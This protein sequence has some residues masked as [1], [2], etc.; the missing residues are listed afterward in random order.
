MYK[1]SSFSSYGVAHGNK[2]DFTGCLISD[3]DGKELTKQGFGIGTPIGASGTI[4]TDGTVE[5]VLSH[6]NPAG[7][8]HAYDA[9]GA[10]WFNVSLDSVRLRSGNRVE[11]LTRA[12][13]IHISKLMVQVHKGVVRLVSTER[14]HFGKSKKRNAGAR[15]YGPRVRAPETST[16]ADS[17]TA[18]GGDQPFV[19]YVRR[20][21]DNFTLLM[22][23]SIAERAGLAEGSRVEIEPV[24][25]GRLV[26]SR[27]K[28][29]FTLDELLAGMT[30]DREHPLEDDTPRGEESL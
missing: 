11:R 6:A 21:G 1:S 25:D 18:I 7:V 5:L 9:D 19:S 26:V 17:I 4:S 8:V 16:N 20:T 28:R 2:K 30:P 15:L 14:S 10:R 27:S 24:A 29:H 12:H 3:R 13:D 22:S 23:Q